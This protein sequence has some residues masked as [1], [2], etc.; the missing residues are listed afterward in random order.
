MSLQSTNIKEQSKTYHKGVLKIE[1]Q[2]WKQNIQVERA[3]QQ[4]DTLRSNLKQF[5]LLLQVVPIL[6][7]KNVQPTDDKS[8]YEKHSI[9]ELL[10]T[11]NN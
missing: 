4:E 6:S 2:Q 3:D 5:L 7:E 11:S 1:L 10:L 8:S 9:S